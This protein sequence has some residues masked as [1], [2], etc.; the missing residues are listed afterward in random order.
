MTMDTTGRKSSGDLK[1]TLFDV[2]KY[3]LKKISDVDFK[4]RK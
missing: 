3:D 4:A 2:K 1:A